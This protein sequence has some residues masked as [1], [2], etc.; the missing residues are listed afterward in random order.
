MGG[1]RPD[2]PAERG[3]AAPP[4]PGAGRTEGAFIHGPAG[5]QRAPHP[6]SQGARRGRITHD[7]VHGRSPRALAYPHGPPLPHPP[8][9]APRPPRPESASPDRPQPPAPHALPLPPPGPE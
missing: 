2:G 1:G 9:H 6:A 5:A 7:P 4:Y 8:P 3:G